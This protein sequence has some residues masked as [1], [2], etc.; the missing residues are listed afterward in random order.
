ME[1]EWLDFAVAI[2]KMRAWFPASSGGQEIGAA[3]V[4]VPK[5]FLFRYP[6]SL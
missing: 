1:S 4:D 3:P 6:F 5:H 2:K